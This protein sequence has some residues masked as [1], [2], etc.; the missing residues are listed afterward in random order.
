MIHKMKSYVLFQLLSI[1]N[2]TNISVKC[3]Y[4]Y[5][6]VTVIDKRTYR[7]LRTFVTANWMHNTFNSLMLSI[8]QPTNYLFK[9]DSLMGSLYN[10]IQLIVLHMFVLLK[11]RPIQNY[12]IEVVLSLL[13][14]L[15]HYLGVDFHCKEE[16]EARMGCEIVELLLQLYK[17]LWGQM[18]ILQHHPPARLT[19]GIDHLVG[20]CETFSRA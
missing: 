11:N 8:N 3:Y 4:N 12:S 10:S 15:M 16:P 18:H 14:S 6:Q 2:T 19:G 17:P 9:Y 7:N 13:T 1:L 20:L 5:F